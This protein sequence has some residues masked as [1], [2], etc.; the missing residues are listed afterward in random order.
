M[1]SYI[2]RFRGVS[3]FEIIR[4]PRPF[5]KFLS[6][7]GLFPGENLIEFRNNP[8]PKLI[9]FEFRKNAVTKGQRGARPTG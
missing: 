1:T 9:R 8:F 5:P 3:S 2:V 4:F 7:G 6:I